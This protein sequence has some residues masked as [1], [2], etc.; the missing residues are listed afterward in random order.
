MLFTPKKHGRDWYWCHMMALY[1]FSLLSGAAAIGAMLSS[2]ID[3]SE[4]IV[5]ALGFCLA[6]WIMWALGRRCSTIVAQLGADDRRP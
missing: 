3:V 1:G 2:D 4:R 5:T 6:A